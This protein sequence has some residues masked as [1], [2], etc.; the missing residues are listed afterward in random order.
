MA[1]LARVVLPEVPHHVTQRGVRSIDVFQSDADRRDYLRLLRINGDRHG[2]RFLAYC[3]MSNHIHLVVV[4][5]RPDSLA[6]GIGEA[7]KAYTRQANFRSGKR[8]F[9]F[10]GRFF[11]CPMDERHTVSAELYV[12]RNPVRAGIVQ[13]PWLYAWSSAA[14]NAGFPGK[15]VLLGRRAIN[16]EVAEWRKL[17]LRNEEEVDVMRG[18]LH[19][20]RPLGDEAFINSAELLTGRRLRLL[21]P[22]R[23]PACGELGVVSPI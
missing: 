7:H 15:D 14:F 11:S 9:L 1:R 22:G 10:Q 17:L 20:G 12:E 3:L 19:T 8:G 5:A 23:K 13:T 21:P 16:I 2:L 4:P 6:R 18:H